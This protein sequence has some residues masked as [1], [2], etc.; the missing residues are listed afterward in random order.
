MV[1]VKNAELHF[2]YILIFLHVHD[3]LKLE[4][5]EGDQNLYL[6]SASIY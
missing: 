3:V 1:S 4:D 2:Y 5:R 6:I